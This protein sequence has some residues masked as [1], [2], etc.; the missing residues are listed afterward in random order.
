MPHDP[1]DGPAGSGFEPSRRGG[2]PQGP[3][4]ETARYAGHG[5]TLALA[6]AAFALLGRWVDGRLGT[7]PLFVLLGSFL[8]LAGG[9]YRMYRELVLAPRS[10]APGPGAESPDSRSEAPDS[11][12]SAP[13]P[14]GGAREDR[15]PDR[16]STDP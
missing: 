14:D 13:G 4:T 8:G 2:E 9:F 3:L 15:R 7:A 12:A 10:E 16:G 6:T 1:P 5:I 11:G